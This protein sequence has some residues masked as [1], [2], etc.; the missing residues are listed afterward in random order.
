MFVYSTK[1]FKLTPFKTP[2]P[3]MG[4]YL[5]IDSAESPWETSFNKIGYFKTILHSESWTHFKT[6]A[7]FWQ[8]S[9]SPWETSLRKQIASGWLYTVNFRFFSRPLC[10]IQW[11]GLI[12][13][14][15][16]R[17]KWD[18]TNSRTVLVTFW[19]P[20]KTPY[21][22]SR[23]QTTQDNWTDQSSSL[24]HREDVVVPKDIFS[25]L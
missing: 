20:F 5:H 14:P 17:G 4:N 16:R 8:C 2:A 11:M 3:S 25:N 12:S 1:T 15:F 24:H 7:S 13:R 19:T 9:N 10:F 22:E 23:R 21:R 6:L 18:R